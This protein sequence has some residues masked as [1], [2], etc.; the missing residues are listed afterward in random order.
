[1][2]L[3]RKIENQKKKTNKKHAR[4][5][6]CRENEYAIERIAKKYI[7]ILDETY[8]LFTVPT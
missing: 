5:T 2:Y 1:M 8:T 7:N 3:L 4:K 6:V